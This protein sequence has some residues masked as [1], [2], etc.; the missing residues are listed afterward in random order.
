MRNF[1][2]GFTLIEL[3]IVVA[4]IGILAAVAM[5]AYQD[6]VKR[7]HVAEGLNLAGGVKSSV[8]EYYAFNG[9]FANGSPSNS[10][11]SLAAMTSITGN[12][13]ESIAVGNSGLIQIAYNS[14]VHGTNKY[15]NLS[16]SVSA[17]GSVVWTCTPAGLF[18]VDRRYLPTSCR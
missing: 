14:K 10:S 6:Y 2:K 11:Y 1:Q 9:R 3:M 8:T 16:P 17:A 12:A 15:L 5:P 7:A 13:V 4:I 18:G